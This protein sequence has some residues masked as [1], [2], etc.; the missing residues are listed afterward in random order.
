MNDLFLFVS[1]STLSNHADI[2][3]LYTYGYNL[4]EVKEVLLDDLNKVTERLFENYI[5]LNAEKCHFMCLGKNIE[6]DFHI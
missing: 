3:T 4:E 1:S 2:N 5:V 6:N